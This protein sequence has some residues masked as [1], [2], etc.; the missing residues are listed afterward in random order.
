MNLQKFYS[1]KKPS[2]RWQHHWGPRLGE[3]II[4]KKVVDSPGGAA[5]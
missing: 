2:L 5:V 1:Q 4:N 3:K